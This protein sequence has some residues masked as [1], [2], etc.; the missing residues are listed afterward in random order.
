M[1][2]CLFLF[3][4][5]RSFRFY[6]NWG[7]K[8]SFTCFSSAALR[9]IWQP[10]FFVGLRS[11]VC[12]RFTEQVLDH[13][14]FLQY[15]LVPLRIREKPLI[16]REVT[17]PMLSGT[18]W[19]MVIYLHMYSKEEWLALV[20]GRHLFRKI[21]SIVWRAQ[22]SPVLSWSDTFISSGVISLMLSGIWRDQVIWLGY[23]KRRDQPNVI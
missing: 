18:W 22:C 21:V 13:G 23:I 4:I 19:N 11:I 8:N 15:Y 20:V 2:D 9:R 3:S 14:S 10:R 5:L 12:F 16:A 17:S 6:C 1:S 7:F